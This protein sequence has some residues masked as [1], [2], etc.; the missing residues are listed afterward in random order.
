MRST[1]GG[2]LED[3]YFYSGVPE[4]RKLGRLYAPA[5]PIWGESDMSKYKKGTDV[6]SHDT[7]LRGRYGR[8]LD[9]S[10]LTFFGGVDTYY[11][12]I[13]AFQQ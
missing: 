12:H 4:V 7:S 10:V 6:S 13:P 2:W 1:Y 11:H 9:T 3:T 5:G 8:G